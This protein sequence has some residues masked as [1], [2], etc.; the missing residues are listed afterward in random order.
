MDLRKKGARA[1]RPR[2]SPGGPLAPLSNATT[3]EVRISTD[4]MHAIHQLY[5]TSSSMQAARQILLG[6]LLSS[7]IVIRR[8]GKDV[9]LTEQFAKHLEGVWL[10]FARDVIDSLLQ[11]GF[12]AV[13]I[14][15]ELPPPFGG[16]NSEEREAKRPRTLSLQTA[17]RQVDNPSGAVNLVPVVCETGSYEVSFVLGG[18]GGYRR[19]YRVA[20]MS[21]SKSYTIDSDVGLFFKTPP[22][23]YGNINSPVA[24][25]FDQASFVAALQELALNAEVTRARTQLVTQTVP[26]PNGSGAAALEP[27]ALFFD[28]ESRALQSSDSQSQAN[29]QA[30]SLGMMA[31]MMEELNRLRTTNFPDSS[32]RPGPVSHLPPEVPPRLFTIP[33]RQQLVP[34]LRAPEARSDLEALLRYSNDAIC[35]SMGVPASIV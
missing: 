1:A 24:T 18:R 33:D 5:Q 12:V 8:K 22:D 14:E 25:C 13:S 16:L 2:Q 10:P 32:G 6:Q 35:A 17:P 11:Y 28:S 26:K 29:E 23:T 15:E 34:N 27:A 30:Q 9:E 21:A 7:G 19:E 3:G 4:Q 31:K 20:S